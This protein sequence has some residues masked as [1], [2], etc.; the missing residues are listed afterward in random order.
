MSSWKRDFASGL[1]VVLPVLVSAYVIAWLYGVVSSITPQRVIRVDLLT[2]LGLS[3]AVA[4]ALV[5]PL[6]VLVVL[7]VFVV[8]VF[9]VGY[10]MRTA[11]GNL[12]EGLIDNMANRVPGLRVVYNASKM[13]AE[14]ALGGTDSLQKPVRVEP[15]PGM[16]LTAFKTGKTTADG[17]EVVF[18]PT[19]PNIT[20]GFVIEV[21]PEE[22]EETDERVEDAL[23]RILSAGF[24]DSD[25]MGGSAVEDLVEVE[26]SE[27]GE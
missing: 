24:G 22:L 17:R 20:T 1:I 9:S 3:E 23:T 26:E 10:L 13:A 15:I 16:R 27:D 2:D 21:P 6:R 12:A 18:M 5:E 7:A 14:T 4:N 25:R 19:A 11:V 8:F